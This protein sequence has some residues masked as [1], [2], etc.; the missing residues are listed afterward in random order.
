MKALV[1]NKL[2]HFHKIKFLFIKHKILYFLLISLYI[3]M[4]SI[5]ALNRFAPPHMN[6][7]TVLFSIISTQNVTPFIW[8]Q[9]RLANF[10]PL[11]LS[12]FSS[13]HL[14]LLLH[15]FIFSLSFFVLIYSIAIIIAK[16]NHINNDCSNKLLA[17]C[18]TCTVS[19]LVLSPF[20]SHVFI[21]EGQPYALSYLLLIHSFLFFMKIPQNKTPN[22]IFCTA[23]LFISFGLNPSILVPATALS[24][25]YSFISKNL[26]GAIFLIIS[27][28]FFIVWGKLSAILGVPTGIKAYNVFDL[29]HT[30]SN[31]LIS[32]QNILKQINLTV[33]SLCLIIISTFD[34]FL[35]DDKNYL[36]NKI[37]N[38]GF[39]FTAIW[40]FI[41]SQ[42]QW[43]KLNGSHFRYF[44]PVF[45][46]LIFY[47]SLKLHVYVS[48]L[49]LKFRYTII[50]FLLFTIVILLYSPFIPLGKYKI[51]EKTNQYISL[52]DKNNVN[53]VAGNYWDV[54]PL[55]FL[56]RSE[57]REIYSYA[58]RS[59]GNKKTT[60]NAFNAAISK[61]GS[62]KVLCLQS[63][64][65]QCLIEVEKIAGR[66]MKIIDENSIVDNYLL[67]LKPDA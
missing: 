27:V 41:F 5:L 29:M 32:S 57:G 25:G 9:D 53:M 28:L 65:D 47:L 19:I 24:V 17:F 37:T 43:I 38:I 30:T 1:E 10:I 36:S 26:R 39:V 49:Y 11:I 18:I 16:I 13:I 4:L 45:L 67:L 31:L 59:E 35:S 63:S 42:N 55:F 34:I 62:V 22:I 46:M 48:K 21:A 51:F 52:L 23:A 64:I 44:F 54:W 33:T 12:T 14:N 8:G 61:N 40:L 15:L 60:L 20:A 6:A 2:V 66:K 3:T 58:F 7:D 56:M 50:V